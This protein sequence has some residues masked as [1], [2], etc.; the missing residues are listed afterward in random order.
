MQSR[1]W[2]VRHLLEA[3]RNTN[4]EGRVVDGVDGASQFSR[5]GMVLHAAE[6]EPFDR[7]ALVWQMV[8]VGGGPD[9]RQCIR[10]QHSPL[11]RNRLS[12]HGGRHHS[13]CGVDSTQNRSRAADRD[14]S[15]K[16]VWDASISRWSNVD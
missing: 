1:E 10:A 12:L 15:M 6:G 2:G 9:S 14:V 13:T 3:R 11:S 5:V 16:G 7:C 8:V 4:E